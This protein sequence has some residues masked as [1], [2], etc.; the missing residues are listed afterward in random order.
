MPPTRRVLATQGMIPYS[1]SKCL[2]LHERV[3]ATLKPRSCSVEFWSYWRYTQTKDVFKIR[4]GANIRK[5]QS[6]VRGDAS[7]LL[8]KVGVNGLFAV[9]YIFVFRDSAANFHSRVKGVRSWMLTP[10]W[11]HCAKCISSRYIVAGLF[12]WRLFFRASVTQG[13]ATGLFLCA[14]SGLCTL[15]QMY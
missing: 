1:I 14:T 12:L 5:S 6:N 10:H 13:K 2:S 15:I 7:W 3:C 4:D 9:L 8:L 11:D